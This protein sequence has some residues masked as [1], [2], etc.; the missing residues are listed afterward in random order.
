M[1]LSGD[2]Q[3]EKGSRGVGWRTRWSRDASHSVEATLWVQTPLSSFS[4]H[5]EFTAC[6]KDWF[7]VLL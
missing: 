7:R 6:R 3:G 2:Q 1:R 5:L 4:A